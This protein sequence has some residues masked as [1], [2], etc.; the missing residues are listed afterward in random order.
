MKSYKYFILAI[1]S[2][3]FVSILCSYIYA[4]QSESVDKHIPTVEDTILQQLG[5]KLYFR[6]TENPVDPITVI[7]AHHSNLEKSKKVSS[8]KFIVH[9]KRS[10]YHIKFT[11]KRLDKVYRSYF[12]GDQDF[13]NNYSEDF[14]TS[15]NQ[16]IEKQ[17]KT[18]DI[19]TIDPLI[20]NYNGYWIYLSRYKGKFYLD[21]HWAWLAS[22]HI[23]DSILTSHS[24][25]GPDPMVI[26]NFEVKRNGDFRLN[27]GY[28]ELVDDNL[29][30]Y[31]SLNG[32]YIVT[33]R[34]ANKFE[35]IEYANN[36]GGLIASNYCD[37]D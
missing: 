23:S 28:Y 36:T 10:S 5:G 29:C 30:V 31:K 13:P 4:T 26:R 34:N 27:D 18:I 37:I 32:S 1:L 14:V 25:D 16:E 7:E 33:A 22:F 15:F 12:E 17:K 6:W 3:L 11:P 24:M 20:K 8:Y 19:I 35:I 9:N 21:D 2:I